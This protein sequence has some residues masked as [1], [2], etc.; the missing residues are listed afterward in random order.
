MLTEAPILAYPDQ[1]L[2]TV[3]DIH[4]D[5]SGKGIGAVLYQTPKNGEKRPV[6]YASRSLT[7]AESV[8]GSTKLEC[9]G[10]IWAIETFRP[11]IY[12]RPF[13]IITD[14]HSLCDM[15]RLKDP[16]GQLA[17]WCSRLQPYDFKV[18][19]KSGKLHVD[20]DYLSRNPQDPAP[21]TEPYN[22]VNHLC[23]LEVSREKE[24][25]F[26]QRQN[27]PD[28]Q[29]RDIKLKPIIDWIENPDSAKKP[30]YIDHFMLKD[31]ILY[32]ANYDEFGQLWRLVI[33]NSLRQNVMSV[34]HEKDGAHL[35]FFKTWHLLKS[36]YYWPG[37]YGDIFQFVK[38]CQIC[39]FYNRPTTLPCGQAFPVAPPRTPFHTIGID[40]IGPF[41]K[42]E[43]H[44]FALVFICH[45]T[46]Y[47]SSYAVSK[48]DT[49]KAIKVLE[50]YL[51][52]VHS[53]PKRIVLDQGSNFTSHAFKDF[54]K[55]HSIELVFGPAYHHQFNGVTERANSTIKST[56]AKRIRER[57][58]DWAKY[59]HEIV[60][61]I[62]ITVN[63]STKFSPF[64]L[65]FGRDPNLSIDNAFPSIPENYDEN[66]VDIKDK[67]E[68]MIPI[69]VRNVIETQ[70]IAKEKHDSRH[71]PIF[72]AIGTLVLY[73]KNDCKPGEVKKLNAKWKGPYVV[74][75]NSRKNTVKLKSSRH[76]RVR[77]FDA[78][79]FQIK[80]Y[81]SEY[82]PPEEYENEYDD[83][84]SD[85][86]TVESLK[87]LKI[88]IPK[89]IAL[90]QSSILPNVQTSNETIDAPEGEPK[91][92]I[93][94]NF[95]RSLSPIAIPLPIEP[96]ALSQN[97]NENQSPVFTSELRRRSPR[98]RRKPDRLG[99]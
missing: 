45:T 22:S 26:L 69:A 62:N 95:N 6:A 54:A 1:S 46:R 34:I 18:I 2:D 85:P 87:S 11:Y 13:N 28:L 56:L 61:A 53:Y 68:A 72:H 36:K 49:D 76:N 96:T 67:R 52:H 3:M 24:M 23:S 98:E 40:F 42:C 84:E 97:L 70:Q 16:I 25:N 47:V 51:L 44:Q 79:V 9:L 92:Q 74:V 38:R 43:H 31:E 15:M 41:P 27:L 5:G 7:R 21:E 4:T 57:Y 90:D 12:G 93:T 59:L 81:I 33:P 80:P 30:K 58:K 20:A 50:R 86:E 73:Q 8:Y 17:R 88:Q 91:N 48:C 89:S 77:F 65:V 14:H 94:E 10:I 19:H 75:E 55:K 37:M 82:I 63:A 78:S 99:Y 60:F 29:R 71:K 32:R 64:R 39:Q 66:E 83:S 35:G